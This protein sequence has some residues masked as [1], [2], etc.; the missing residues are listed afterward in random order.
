MKFFKRS[1][2]N[3][4]AVWTRGLT[5][6]AAGAVNNLFRVMVHGRAAVRASDFWGSWRHGL[7]LS[8]FN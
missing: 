7:I 3:D 8:C 6:R 2:R 1:C 5:G 4:A